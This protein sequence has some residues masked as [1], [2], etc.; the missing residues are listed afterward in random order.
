M[1][2]T[3]RNLPRGPARRLA[4]AVAALAVAALLAAACTGSGGEVD[5]R[6]DPGA[7]PG[8][9]GGRP[10]PPT[11]VRGDLSG[12]VLSGASLRREGNAVTLRFTISSRAEDTVTIGDLLGPN[13]LA[14]PATFEASGAYL[15][16]GTARKRYDVLRDGEACR[17]AKVPLGIDPGQTLEL[18]TTFPDPG[19]TAELSA[20]VPHFAP[21]DGLKIQN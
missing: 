2:M 16:D 15:Y 7:G 21:L 4:A 3:A 8:P 11:S 17:C 1:V 12:L 20:V 18:F 5:R 6:Q 13:G 10:Q 9:A 14:R 19:P